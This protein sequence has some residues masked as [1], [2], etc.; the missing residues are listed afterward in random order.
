M[1]KLFKIL[2][3]KIV[4]TLFFFLLQI[5]F[6][7]VLLLAL[8]TLSAWV[9]IGFSV[10]SLFVCLFILG[11][12]ANPGYKLAWVIPILLLPL[13]GGMMYISFGRTARLRRK[14]RKRLQKIEESTVSSY[15]D[16]KAQSA[17]IVPA[18]PDMQRK[19]ATLIEQQG[20][21]PLYD[22][23]D[24]RYYPVGE[25]FLQ[26]LLAD[27][28]RA[29][30]YIFLEYFILERGK[31]WDAVLDVLR[32]KATQGVDVRLIYDD[33]GCLFTLPAGYAK[34]LRAL[35]IK[36]H[37]FNKIKPTFNIRMNNRTHRKI[38][39]VDGKVA[40]TGG[41]NLADEYIN[42]KDKYGYWKDTA[43]RMQGKAAH[44]FTVMFLQFWELLEKETVPLGEYLPDVTQAT[45][46]ARGFVQPLA[47]YPDQNVQLIEKA[48]MTL[49]HNADRYV[50][51]NTPYLIPDNEFV[52][53]L[54]LAAQNGVDVRITMPHI[55]DKKIV[56]LMSRSFY[57]VLLKAGVKIYEYL[58]G[59]VHAKSMLCDD[60]VAYVGT[61]NLDYRS[62]YLH[63][64]CGAFVY[65]V[66]ALSDI[67]ADYLATLDKCKQITY[68]E[69]TD[70]TP[71]TKLARSVLR[72]FAPL[73]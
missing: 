32:Q 15:D 46:P 73:L 65:D 40:Y 11:K 19:I 5:A 66:P 51:I 63:Y 27:L 9:Y 20:S 33:I 36:V 26:A 34:K 18:L 13:F 8:T 16:A 57:P 68:E 12:D 69:A 14:D 37:V 39:V 23:T 35:G 50:Y 17:E 24:V 59:F 60:S 72:L 58:P 49:L 38:A 54:C 42:A 47:S 21:F 25:L 29:E 30:R 56:F 4:V 71:L 45:L 62:F 70:V 67:K 28:Q 10:L 31:C 55:P 1:K 61:C 2:T 22:G 64:E 43:I 48:L 6:T 7:V 53:A 41:L 52:T 44:S 3:N